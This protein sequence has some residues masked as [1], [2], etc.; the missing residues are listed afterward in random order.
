MRQ[1]TEVEALVGAGVS[2]TRPLLG[3]A[4]EVQGLVSQLAASQVL[5]GAAVC[6]TAFRGTLQV[7]A[8]SSTKW[9]TRG[10]RWC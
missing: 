3:P 6:D 9:Q 2:R 10:Y 8:R 1:L 5:H 7:K 4:E